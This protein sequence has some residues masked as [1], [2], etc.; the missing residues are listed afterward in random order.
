MDSESPVGS[1]SLPC[2]DTTPPVDGGPRTFGPPADGPP[3][4]LPDTVDSAP[5]DRPSVDNPV[6]V[7]QI[8]APGTSP[9]QSVVNIMREY[10]HEVGFTQRFK[11]DR[12]GPLGNNRLRFKCQQS[13]EPPAPKKHEDPSKH[14]DKR[15][16][17]IG[18]PYSVTVMRTTRR[19]GQRDGHDLAWVVTTVHGL[20]HGPCPGIGGNNHPLFP[21]KQDVIPDEALPSPVRD[22][23][24]QYVNVGK[25]NVRSI[26]H[27]LVNEFPHVLIEERQLRNA[28]AA[29]RVKADGQG[30]C[31]RLLEKLLTTQHT[32]DPDMSISQMLDDDDHLLGVLWVTGE[33]KRAWLECGSDILIHDNTYNLDELGYKLGVFS[34]VSQRGTTIPLGT[35]FILDE[36]MSAYEWQLGE[37]LK[38]MGD[39][40]P[41]LVI[42]D[43]DPAVV[44]VLGAVFPDA[45]HMW[46]LWHMLRN[47]FKNCKGRVGGAIGKL[48]SDFMKVAAT[49]TETAFL[50]R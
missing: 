18:C 8:L 3:S 46:C 4:C 22:K 38:A 28:I 17:V 12:P 26:E 14:R 31:R 11:Q 10:S 42:T 34:G 7:G 27:L 13:G 19:P 30:Q 9:V 21:H 23:I 15:S 48:L 33:E 39:L 47:I 50:A 36:E 49:N 44:A 24:E 6:S 16:K 45:L 29:V 32:Q 20:C 1:T 41:T 25:C 43:S 2:P 40:Q 35:C 37:W 5:F